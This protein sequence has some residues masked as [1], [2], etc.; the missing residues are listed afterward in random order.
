MAVLLWTKWKSR[1]RLKKK[2]ITLLG[3]QVLED[4]ELFCVVLDRPFLILEAFGDPFESLVKYLVPWWS[5]WWFI[6]WIDSLFNLGQGLSVPLVF[7]QVLEEVF[8]HACI[9]ACYYSVWPLGREKDGYL[10][11]PHL[12]YQPKYWVDLRQSPTVG[13]CLSEDRADLPK[14]IW[15]RKSSFVF[16]GH[17]WALSIY[18]LRH[19]IPLS[20][21]WRHT[22][23][24]VLVVPLVKQFTWFSSFLE[25]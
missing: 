8:Y 5:I 22:N 24:L 17:L 15:W 11:N 2:K 6:W 1:S 21:V 12:I 14:G 16:L 20:G 25:L 3:C 9:T 13:L 18:S 10:G 23:L 4:S 19:W 7:C